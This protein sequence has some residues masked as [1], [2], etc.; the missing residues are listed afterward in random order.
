M[1]EKHE[2]N[3]AG[4]ERIPPELVGKARSGDQAAFA[5]LYERT[6]AELYRSVRSMVRDEDLAWDILQDSYI[7]AWR[8]LDKL[9]TD[10]AFLPCLRR[11]AVNVTA[12]EMA[13]KLPMTFTDLSGDEEDRPLELPDLSTDAQPELALDRKETSRLVREILSDLPQEQQL[14]VGMHYYEDMPIQEIAKTLQVAP[15]TVKAQLHKGRKRIEAGVRALEKQGVKLYGLSPLPFL[16][17]LLRRLEPTVKEEK[18]TLTGILAEGPAAGAAVTAMTAG[19]AFLHGLGVKLLAVA[20]AA[21]LLVGGKLAYDTLKRGNGPDIGDER[22]TVVETAEPKEPESEPEPEPD[23]LWHRLAELLLDEDLTNRPQPSEPSDSNEPSDASEPTDPSDAS[24]PTDS[25]DASEPPDASATTKPSDSAEAPDASDSPQPSGSTEPSDS[26]EPTSSADPTEPS[27]EPI[28]EATEPTT[29]ATEPTTEATEPITEATEPITEATE[30]PVELITG[31]CGAQGDNLT[32]TLNP[33]SGLLTIEGSGSM[34]DYTSSSGSPWYAYRSDIKTVL[35][36]AGL[37]TIG[38]Y[39]FHSC[40]SLTSV[41]F[42]EGV[43]TIGKYA[44]TSCSALASVSLPES[45]TTVSEYAFS[46]SG[47]KTIRIPAAVTSFPSNAVDQCASMTSIT[48]DTGNSRYSSSDGLLLSKD[49]TYMYKCPCGRSGV[50]TIPD[51]VTYVLGI[52]YCDKLTAVNFPDSLENINS[53]SHC[54]NITSISLPKNIAALTFSV[55]FRN[56]SGMQA[57]YV[58]TANPNFTS[59]DGVLFKKD[60]T[61]LCRYPEGRSGS[62]TVPD[63]VTGFFSYAFDSCSGLTSITFPDSL[64]SVASRTFFKCTGLTNVTLPDG[65]TSIDN[66]AFGYCSNLSRITIPA[67]VTSIHTDAFQSCPSLT[68][69]GKAGSYAETYANQHGIPF[70]AAP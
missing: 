63:G 42:P 66:A 2:K 21:A 12:T 34:K 39:A 55:T 69:C 27:A 37:Q 51:G 18:Q 17:A 6:N 9:E 64:R 25:S 58:D 65:V 52:T 67:S 23:D 22:P 62:Y 33:N 49:G 50:L 43:D 53:F 16:L 46:S 56:M 8:G 35:L 14:I 70:E 45:L 30:P 32:W 44:F 54:S 24:E 61:T 57:Y 40:S 5:E 10:G 41:T 28:T 1:R 20:A 29:E 13:K 36:P 26:V 11:I 60:Q 48:V 3:S 7:R 4:A 47:L 15:G 59:R 68:I 38:S 19:Q 31:V